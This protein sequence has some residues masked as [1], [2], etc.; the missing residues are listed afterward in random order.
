MYSDLCTKPGW[1]QKNLK[2]ER[3]L[4]SVDCPGG[5]PLDRAAS[6]KFAND[7]AVFSVSPCAKYRT[8][9]LCTMCRNDD[10]VRTSKTIGGECEV[11]AS[12]EA[13]W[14]WLVFVSI[15]ALI[16]AIVLYYIML[17]NGNRL[18]KAAAQEVRMLEEM[19]ENDMAVGN[20]IQA[21][22][23]DYY[24]HGNTVTIHGPPSPIPNFMFKMKI[25]VGF[26][27]IMSNLMIGLDIA[28]PNDFKN[29]LQ[30]FNIINLDFFA[31][32][33]VACVLKT[34]YF[35]KVWFMIGGVPTSLLVLWI[36]FLLPQYGRH[37]GAD[38]R[39]KRKAARQRF[40]SLVMFT[41]FLVYPTVSSTILRLYQ[42]KEVYGVTYLRSD[43][44]ILCSK[45]DVAAKNAAESLAT[46]TATAASTAAAAAFQALA[47]NQSAF[48]GVNA[49]AKTAANITAVVAVRASTAAN[50]TAAAAKLAA[51]GDFGTQWFTH[52]MLVLPALVL[53]PLGIPLFMFHMLRRYRGRFDELSV[54]AELGFLYDAYERSLWWWEMLDMGHKLSLV[55]L[56]AFVPQKQ[57]QVMVAVT[58]AF[59]YMAAILVFKPYLRKADDR[60]HQFAQMEIIFGLLT[61]YWLGGLDEP[62]AEDEERLLTAILIIACFVFFFFFTVG[63]SYSFFKVFNQHKWGKRFHEYCSG[64]CL[65][66][67]LYKRRAKRALQ[68]SKKKQPGEEFFEGIRNATYQAKKNPLSTYVEKLGRESILEQRETAAVIN[69][70]RPPLA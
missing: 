5:C 30:L 57:W 17:R 27:Q 66:H 33:S 36:F 69:P 1:F 39:E 3:C 34:N 15:A 6:A 44:S 29:F 4:L 43:F 10:I 20:E 49:T 19:A 63:I 11:C 2:F 35:H 64:T 48:A 13:N 40:W 32:A 52:V 56:V 28:W 16:C 18:I 53:I 62:M 68:L 31:G 51:A 26:V 9:D 67:T 50:A 23:H 59:L 8:G 21:Q 60:V 55:A 37:L 46:Q 38:G 7:S 61:A 22:V 41:L 45:T 58:I 12:K 24:R 65:C 42:C 70:D 25:A 47:A 14:I 54:R